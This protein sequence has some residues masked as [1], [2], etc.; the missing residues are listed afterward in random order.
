MAR[1][2]I[3][4]DSNLLLSVIGRSL[5]RAGHTV[6]SCSSPE[7]ALVRPGQLRKGENVLVVDL[8][9]DEKREMAVM[10]KIRIPRLKVLFVAGPAAPVADSGDSGLVRAFAPADRHFLR[11]PFTGN[12]LLMKIDALLAGEMDKAVRTAGAA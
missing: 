7:F 3:P 10:L 12:E 8:T 2:W 4:D 5:R 11:K 9:T 6:V 1:I